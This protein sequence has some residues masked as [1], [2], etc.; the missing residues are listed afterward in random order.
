MSFTLYKTY[1]PGWFIKRRLLNYVFNDRNGKFYYE[2][3][4]GLSR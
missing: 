1:K 4:L 2:T 3:S